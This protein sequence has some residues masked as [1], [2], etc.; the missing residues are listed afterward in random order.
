MLTDCDIPINV[1]V[2]R[3]V[4]YWLITATFAVGYFPRADDRRTR[5][6]DSE[7]AVKQLVELT[8][9]ALSAGMTLFTGVSDANRL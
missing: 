9:R 2:S 3:L 5:Q 4:I 7:V 1:H 6:Q 8:L